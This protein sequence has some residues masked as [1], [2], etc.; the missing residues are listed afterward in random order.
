ML[1]LVI[2]ILYLNYTDSSLQAFIL[3]IQAMF[4]N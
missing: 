3:L 2:E 1:Q 4:L